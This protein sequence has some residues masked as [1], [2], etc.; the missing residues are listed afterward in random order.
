VCI[1]V[2]LPAQ[3]AEVEGVIVQVVAVGRN[4]WID[5]PRSEKG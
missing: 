1:Y 2:E 4:I 3:R 5:A